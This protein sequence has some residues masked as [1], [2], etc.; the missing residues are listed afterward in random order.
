MIILICDN[1]LKMHD[2]GVFFLLFD[3]CIYYLVFV[4]VHAIDPW[5]VSK[6]GAPFVD[7]ITSDTI[8][9]WLH[10]RRHCGRDLVDE[11]NDLSPSTGFHKLDGPRGFA[12]SFFPLSVNFTDHPDR[13]VR[14]PFE[15]GYILQMLF[16]WRLIGYCF[17]LYDRTGDGNSTC[18]IGSLASFLRLP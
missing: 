12:F 10:L 17:D 16:S 13:W 1:V 6:P 3:F 5:G 9:L 15:P 14:Y 4:F 11:H 7:S 2:S 8:K 18:Q